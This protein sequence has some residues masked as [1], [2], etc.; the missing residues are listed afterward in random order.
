M[1]V[2]RQSPSVLL[3]VVSILLFF[4]LVLT[5]CK[6]HKDGPSVPVIASL[7][8]DSGG[9]GTLVHIAGSNLGKDGL[10]ATIQ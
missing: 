10:T 2:T 5:A 6:K 3:F 1:S 9:N 7:S 4:I 8:A